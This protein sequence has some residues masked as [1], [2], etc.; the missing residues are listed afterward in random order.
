MFR[1][2]RN[3]KKCIKPNFLLRTSGTESRAADFLGMDNQL[4]ET[5]YRN[6]LLTELVC[7]DE[8]SADD[9]P[10]LLSLRSSSRQAMASIQKRMSEDGVQADE[11]QELRECYRKLEDTHV[12]IQAALRRILI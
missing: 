3:P 2:T 4:A 5:A 10:D 11:K 1:N 12:R 7:E 8:V 6:A 9:V